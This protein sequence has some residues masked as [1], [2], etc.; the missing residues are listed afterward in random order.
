MIPRP[1]WGA[2]PG[3]AD[4]TAIAP[5]AMLALMDALAALVANLRLAGEGD[6]TGVPKESS[7]VDRP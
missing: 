5:C 3:E 1:P 2:N 7:D 6:R 4:A